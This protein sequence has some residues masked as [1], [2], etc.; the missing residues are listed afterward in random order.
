MITQSQYFEIEDYLQQECGIIEP[1]LL[2]EL[3]DHFMDGIE[4]ARQS[5]DEFVEA[6]EVV[7]VDFGGKAGV[8]KIQREWQVN[9]LKLHAKGLFL[10]LC[11]YFQRPY[12]WVVLVLCILVP[13]LVFYFNLRLIGWN[14]KPNIWL[15]IGGGSFLGG[16]MVAL[17]HYFQ[18]KSDFGSHGLQS[19]HWFTFVVTLIGTFLICVIGL[20]AGS[21]TMPVYAQAMASF[22][23]LTGG[24]MFISVLRYSNRELYPQYA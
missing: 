11:S 19:R 14:N 1:T 12:L 21:I 20:L 17:V 18:N 10:E 4:V 22:F 5:E 6:F 13:V 16:G 7:K 9:A 8:G 3:I 2:E 23:T 24:L 15:G